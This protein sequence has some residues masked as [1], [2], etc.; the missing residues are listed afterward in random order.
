MTESDDRTLR[1]TRRGFL[2]ATA[3]LVAAAGSGIGGNA[4]TAVAAEAK[5]SPDTT[6]RGKRQTEPF[7][8]SH[9]SGIVTPAQTNTYFA[10]FDL[11]ATKRDAVVDLFRRWTSA[12]ARMSVGQ[13]AEPL[14]QDA[15]LPAADS[16]DALGLPPSRL[17]LTFGFGAG[18]FV[19]DGK[20]RY[21]L[22]AHRPEALVD[23]PV[24]AGDQLVETRTGG[25]LSVQACADDAQIAFHAVRQLARLA[26]DV[27][28]IRWV[29]S[30]FVADFGKGAT[31]R[32]LMGFKDGTGN[33][34]ASDPKA[35]AEFVWVGG[36]GPNW[37][38]GGSYVVA[39]RSRIALEHWDRMK[40]GFQEQ[41]FGR[42]KLSGAPLGKQ[43]ELD[44]VDLDAA[45]HDGNPIMPENSHVR[46]AHHASNDGARIL[47]RSYSYNDGVNFTA[48][49]WPPWRQGMEY[50]SGLLFVCY[51]RD[52]RTGFI[53]IF[54]RMSK[55]DMMNQFVTNTGSGLFAC[56]GG[57]A[58]GAFI[59]QRLFEGA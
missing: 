18:L 2:A 9:Q 11:V 52:P 27:A 15:Q 13:T 19:K 42:H 4:A 48:E 54:E 36:E 7:W 41:T 39:R 1:A 40:V 5:I 31:P 32:N 17:T 43:H 50:D 59:G 35:M 24:F 45:D 8:G 3:G 30:G 33:P 37:M 53:K 44:P 26:Y 14:D 12:A 10:S 51:Q 21:G 25:D 57:I 58:K 6:G 49:R 56:P 55:F 46:L 38:R 22:A 16:G 47:R 34:A 29:Q 28:E 20:D 23:M